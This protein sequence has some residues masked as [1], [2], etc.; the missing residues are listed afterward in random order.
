MPSR[1][2]GDIARDLTLGKSRSILAIL[3]VK[4]FSKK[5]SG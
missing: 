4:N 3:R 5:R 1:K 2:E